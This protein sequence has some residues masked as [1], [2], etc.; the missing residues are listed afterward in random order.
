MH[1]LQLKL[2]E[3]HQ[4]RARERKEHQAQLAA[5]EAGIK[6]KL[7]ALKAQHKLFRA[8]GGF[9]V[10]ARGRQEQ[11]LWASKPECAVGSARCCVCFSGICGLLAGKEQQQ[12]KMKWA[13]EAKLTNTLWL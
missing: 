8:Q 10:R 11:G 2:K 3:A 13:R 1:D 4:Q 5:L 6:A 12:Q 9:A 7:G